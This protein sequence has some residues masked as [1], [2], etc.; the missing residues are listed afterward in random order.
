MVHKS[1]NE[2]QI[3]CIAK[4]PK[5]VESQTP[6]KNPEKNNVDP[7]TTQTNKPNKLTIEH[8]LLHTRVNEAREMK[9]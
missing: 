1:K 7:L 3:T 8:V 2:V 6:P 4:S 5:K 9:L